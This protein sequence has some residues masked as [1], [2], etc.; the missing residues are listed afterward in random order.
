MVGKELHF[1]R[2]AST[3]SSPEARVLTGAA[4]R[5]SRYANNSPAGAPYGSSYGGAPSFPG[6]NSPNV[7]HTPSRKWYDPEWTGTALALPRTLSLLNRW[8]RFFYRYDPIVGGVIDLHSELPHSNAALLGIEDQYIQNH[9]QAAVDDIDLFNRLP[10]ITREYLKIG[11]AFPYFRWDDSKGYFSSMILQNPDFIQIDQSRFAD[12]EDRYSLVIDPQLRTLIEQNDPQFKDY[13]RRLPLEFVRA[14]MYGEK[15]PLPFD[16]KDLFVAL[17]KRNSPTDIRG[18]SIIDRVFK[19]LIYEDKLLDSQ[20]AIA[21]NFIFPLRII[22]I[23]N[24]DFT[25]SPAQLD[26]FQELLAQKQFDPNFYLLTHNA[27]A[28]ESHNLASDLMSAAN[29]WER[30]DKIKM[31]ALGTSQNFM[32]GESTYASAHVGYQTVLARY[33][34]MRSYLVSRC[35]NPFFKTIAIRNEFFKR[36]LKEINGQYR[37]SMKKE[38]QERPENLILPELGWEKQ[39]IIREDESFLNFMAGLMGKQNI[40]NTTFFSALGLSYKEEL[41]RSDRDKKLEE[42][43]GVKIKTTPGSTDAKEQAAD[44]GGDESSSAGDLFSSV[45]GL[46]R[47]KKKADKIVPMTEEE[48]SL[49]FLWV[50]AKNIHTK[51]LERDGAEKARSAEDIYAELASAHKQGVSKKDTEFFVR[52]FEPKQH[53]ALHFFIDKK[54][55]E[56]PTPEYYAQTTVSELE[57]KENYALNYKQALNTGVIQALKQLDHITSGVSFLKSDVDACLETLVD[58]STKQSKK[59]IYGRSENIDTEFISNFLKADLANSLAR[60]EDNLE[61][62]RNEVR[63]LGLAAVVLGTVIHYANEKVESVRVISPYTNRKMVNLSEI[64]QGGVDSI[65]PYISSGVIP[66]IY[67]VIFDDVDSLR[68]FGFI[69]NSSSNGFDISNCPTYF[70][71]PL[72]SY[73]RQ[74]KDY[75]VKP[76]KNISFGNSIE[77]IPEFYDFV[78]EKYSIKSDIDSYL[79]ENERMKFADKYSYRVKDTLFIDYRSAE[80]FSSDFDMLYYLLPFD[81]EKYTESRFEEIRESFYVPENHLVAALES[82]KLVVLAADEGLLKSAGTKL[83]RF[84]LVDYYDVSGYPVVDSKPEFV[85]GVL[86]AYFDK[87]YSLD[88]TLLHIFEIGTSK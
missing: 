6:G 76:P 86:R 56:A 48:R 44:G 2:S 47:R 30:I 14:I 25:P 82:K 40:S 32:T 9:Y 28:Y 42:R 12:D 70:I 64:Y 61:N 81:M 49:Q 13:K 74:F 75:M 27:V 78:R 84:S 53:S 80:A 29:E 34:A 33:K 83:G 59:L 20:I 22:K 71:P 77:H 7:S 41:I 5:S 72:L 15:L 50:V 55:G 65:T 79:I 85:K 23:G 17:V 62:R 4:G 66:T 57:F 3:I 87:K 39:L 46:F 21:D 88:D 69:A 1:P 36:P 11:E 73:V 31:L 35:L 37:V 19:Y 67:P 52:E 26:A 43:L 16:A 63:A 24:E 45:S 18:T 68:K 51:E 10:E 58:E 60:I 8:R 38:E 54:S